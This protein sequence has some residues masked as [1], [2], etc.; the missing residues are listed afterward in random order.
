VGVVA[1][2]LMVNYTASQYFESKAQADMFKQTQVFAFS[3]LLADSLGNM[4]IW[5]SPR[6]KYEK[7]TFNA[8]QLD[9]DV[10]ADTQFTALRDPDTDCMVQIDT[11]P[12][13]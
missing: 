5:T 6:C 10:M 13:A 9:S 11:F 7:F 2:Q 12:V 3:M 8:S 1:G 4:M